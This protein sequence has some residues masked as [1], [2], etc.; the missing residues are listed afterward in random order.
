VPARPSVEAWPEG[1]ARDLEGPEAFPKGDDGAARRVE[2]IQTHLSRVYLVGER[3]YKLPR[4]VDVGF[5]SFARRA[6]R[7]RECLREVELNRRLAP[8]VYLGVAS[9]VE[10]G[11]RYRI[12]PLVE[13]PD[14]DS[15]PEDLELVVVMRRLPEGRDAQSLLERGQLGAAHLKRLAGRLAEFHRTHSLGVPAPFDPPGWQAR[16]ADPIRANFDTLERAAGSILERADVESLRSATETALE[17]HAPRFEVRR[18]EGR[19]VDAHGDLHLQHVWFETDDAE[20]VAIDAL[21]FREDLRRIDAASEMAFLAMDLRYRGR[22]DLAEHLLARYAAERDDFGLYGVVDLFASYRAAVRAKV[23]ALAAMDS[24]IDA[25][26]RSR[27]A[28]SARRHVRAAS[29]H[30]DRPP[31][32]PLVLVGGTVGSGKSTVARALASAGGVP[33]V[34]SDAIRSVV[35]GRDLATGDRYSADARDRVYR[36][37]L[38]RARPV[39]ASG[40]PVILDATFARG[41]HRKGARSLANE[42][43]ARCWWVEARCA[44]ETALDRL[45]RRKARGGDASEAGPAQLE[46]SIREF[47]PLAPWTAGDAFVVE[48]DGEDA[49]A[50]CNELATRLASGP[51]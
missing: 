23:A 41:A 25:D 46:G 19:A 31:A 10:S 50:F 24:D 32:G 38:E 34:A 7:R 44:R 3:V 21:V 11:G 48:T 29:S 28:E 36:A 12:G 14:P 51:A 49:E 16:N 6:E 8:D 30:L 33:I 47:E 45:E 35:V 4:A 9:I 2:V 37:M 13:D 42:V 40:R 17:T 27:S 22:P 15:L 43:G 26:Q 1:L 5:V 39:L 20:P 18:R